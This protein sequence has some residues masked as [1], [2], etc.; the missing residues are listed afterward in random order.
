MSEKI[1]GAQMIGFEVMRGRGEHLVMYVV[2]W[3]INRDGRESD[4]LLTF[5]FFPYTCT[6][7]DT[8]KQ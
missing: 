2:Q 8:D 6:S 1:I 5:L 4:R 3:N 7:M